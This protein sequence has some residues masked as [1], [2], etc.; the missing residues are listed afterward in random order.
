[1]KKT[2]LDLVHRLE[3]ERLIVRSDSGDGSKSGRRMS[4]TMLSRQS[5]SSSVGSINLNSEQNVSSPLNVTE[6]NRNRNISDNSSPNL[7]PVPMRSEISQLSNGSDN[8]SNVSMS[9][10]NRSRLNSSHHTPRSSKSC[11]IIFVIQ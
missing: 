5:T 4:S 10:G 1:M 8:Q 7:R 9:T 6:G 11:L 3:I 2:V